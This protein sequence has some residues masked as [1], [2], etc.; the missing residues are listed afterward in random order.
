[1]S[2]TYRVRPSARSARR[3]AVQNPPPGEFPRGGV[4]AVNAAVIEFRVDQASLA[5]YQ[6]PKCGIGEPDCSVR[7][8]GQVIRGIEALS[9]IVRDNRLRRLTILVRIGATDA[10]S[11]MFAVKE[12]ALPIQRIAIHEVGPIDHDFNVAV[13]IPTEQPAVRH[14]GPE[15]AIVSLLPNGSF[16]VQR[17]FVQAQER[18]SGPHYGSQPFVID[19]H[20]TK[21]IDQLRRSGTPQEAPGQ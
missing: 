6:D 8:D 16:A 12:T 18:G 13:G 3:S 7:R 1:M 10:A 14:V 19:L 20:A 21:T 15:E 9:L 4:K 5:W 11:T 17:A 2:E